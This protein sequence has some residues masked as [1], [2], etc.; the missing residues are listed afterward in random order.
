MRISLL[1][2]GFEAVSEL[3]VGRQLV[4]FFADNNFHSFTGISAFASQASIR[5]LSKHI[6][7]AKKHLDCITIVTGVD[8]KVTSKEALEELLSLNIN[9]Y[10]F[11]QPSI[12]I[13]HPK[14][15]L[16]K[17]PKNQN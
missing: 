13:F 17:D 7:T 14:I 10:V 8:Q 4:K 16:F 15:Y 3:S 11:Y 1:G 9:A 12:T 2:Q 6:N 5:G